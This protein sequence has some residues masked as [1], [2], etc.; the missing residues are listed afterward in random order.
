M[1]IAVESVSVPPERIRKEF[2]KESLES[3]GTSMRN[4]GQ[5]QP[6]VVKRLNGPAEIPTYEL[7]AGE[8]RLLATK[9]LFTNEK[10]IKGLELGQ[11]EAVVKDSMPP[12]VQLMMEFEEND[13][14]EDFTPQDR[15][16]FIRRFHEMMQGQEKKWTNEMT[17]LCLN[18][19]PASISHY[20]RVEEAMKS[21]PL[22]AGAATLSAAV[23]RMKFVE[24]VENREAKAK[25][26]NPKAMDDASKILIL[27][28]ALKLIKEVS[29]ESVD[30]INFDPPWGDDTGHKSNENWES[31][32]DTTITADGIIDTLLPE[33]FRVLRNDRFLVYWFRQWAY[34]DMCSRLEAAGFNLTFTRTP[35]IWHK[36][37]KV[38]DQQ[39]SPEKALITQYEMFLFARKGDPVFR[40]RNR[41]NVFVYPR[42][43]LGAN[44]H[45]TEKP[46]GLMEDIVKLCSVPGELVLDPTAG[47]ASVLD[48]ALRN[49]RK[50]LG[51]EMGGEFHQRGTLRLAEYLKGV[52]LV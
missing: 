30:L 32:D 17:A 23:K 49:N 41:G 35:N 14:R 22:V 36:P 44:I 18:L 9:Y 16:K 33:L 40:E 24:A 37:D 43:T 31:F 10:F 15:A 7:I 1:I 47:S 39:R 26:D 8:R 51:F 5:L 29:N 34:N 19:S 42:N 28:D 45:P 52:K 12:Y 20:L 4:L 6:I 48:A 2:T 46:L 3:L 21:D 38:S 27:G 25:L 50:A 11:I 13:K